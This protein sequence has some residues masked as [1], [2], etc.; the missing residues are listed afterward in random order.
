MLLSR[1]HEPEFCSVPRQSPI[2]TPDCPHIN[3]LFNRPRSLREHLRIP[4]LFLGMGMHSSARLSSK[5]ARGFPDFDEL[6]CKRL[7]SPYFHPPCGTRTVA[8]WSIHLLFHVEW[9]VLEDGATFWQ[10]LNST[11]V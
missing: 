7:G 5:L 9:L 6:V 10:W 3:M 1:F 2:I 4:P 11:V 8:G